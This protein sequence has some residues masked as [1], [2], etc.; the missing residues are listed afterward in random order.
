MKANERMSPAKPK[1][2][3][4]GGAKKAFTLIELL[5]VIAIIA[6]LA[7]MLLPAL[8]KA[9]ERARR[10]Q[11]LNNEKQILISFLAY[12]YDNSD[13]FPKSGFYWIWDLDRNAADVMLSANNNFQKSCYCPGT[14]PRFTDQDNINLWNLSGN[15]RVLGY[16][17]ALADGGGLIKTNANP[18]IQPQAVQFG[19]LLVQPGHITERVLV[20][21]ATISIPSEHDEAQRWNY[22]YTEISTGSYTVNGVKKNHLSPHLKGKVPLGGNLGMLDGH[23]E[24]RKFEKMHVRGYGGAG[25]GIDNGTCPT[26]WW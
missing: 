15:Y 26:Y 7:A 8:A 23:A 6:I 17:V 10:T 22:N 18:T 19:M 21:D 13:K 12:A 16:A 20:A 3:V 24:W 4:T 9:K 14:G 2:F 25:G 5:V 11:C 1:A